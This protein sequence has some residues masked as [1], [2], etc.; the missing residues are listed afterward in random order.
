MCGIVGFFNLTLPPGEQERAL[1]AALDAVRVRGPDDSGIWINANV[2]FGHQRLAIIDK[3]GA[4]Q[5]WRDQETGCVLNYNGEIYNFSILREQLVSRGHAFRSR[6]DTEVLM[7]AYLE[8]GQACVHYLRGMYA[9]ALYDP[10][11][12]ALWLVRDRVGVKPLF[13][14]EYSGGWVFA[15]SVAALLR[16]P[17]FEKRACLPAISHYLTTSRIGFGHLTLVEGIYSLQPG[18]WMWINHDRHNLQRYW[19]Y[20]ILSPEDKQRPFW[21][22]ALAQVQDLLQQSVHEQ[23]VS[24]AGIGGFLSGGLDSCILTSLIEPNIRPNYRLANVGYAQAGFNEWEYV[25][26]A[27]QFYG[28][29]CEKKALVPDEYLPVAKQL[30]RFKGLPLATPNEVPIHHL[31]TMVKPW[32]SVALSG[33]GAD[34]VFAGYSISYFS[35]YDYDRARRQPPSATEIP[36]EIDQALRRYYGRDYFFSPLDHF[37][38]LHSW[39]PFAAKIKIFHADIWNALHDDQVLLDYY[40]TLFT[41]LA[42]CS[43]FDQY[44]HVHARVNLESLL[45]RIDSATMAASLEARVPFTDHRLIEYVF[46]LPDD[47]KIDWINSDAARQGSGMN[48]IESDQARLLES[49]RLL[50]AAYHSVVPDAIQHRPKMSFPVPSLSWFSTLWREQARQIITDSPWCGIL[51]DREQILNC[52]AT[53][54]LNSSMLALWPIF[55]LC[56]WQREWQII[57]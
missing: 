45:F 52:L 53:P 46:S 33:E 23:C 21:N 27:S 8:W 1:H 47:Y 3:E 12:D 49:K 41:H 16:L 2:Y 39:I 43:T 6:S 56:L 50:R 57:I 35:A 36:T 10:R 28:L 42:A 29:P 40:S 20:P 25:D 17:N 38:L 4:R 44:L 31:A 7:R 55:N 11:Q 9:F 15:S 34:E 51:F 13:Y 48:A 19:E 26:I 37:F 18:E 30:I 54:E 22:D 32:A 14:A 24:E 5:P